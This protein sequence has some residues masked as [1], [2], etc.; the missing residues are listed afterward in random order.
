[1]V[2]SYVDSNIDRISPEFGELLVEFPKLRAHL[3]KVRAIP[4]IAAFIAK[5]PKTPM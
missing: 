3:D 2:A 1:M 5:R 4:R